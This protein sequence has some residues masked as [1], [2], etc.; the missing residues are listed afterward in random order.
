VVVTQ[1]DSHRITAAVDRRLA[2]VEGMIPPMPAWRGADE[3]DLHP[4]RIGVVA[5]PAVR[6]GANES[7]Q[8]VLVASVATIAVA[9]ALSVFGGFGVPRPTPGWADRFP[10]Q[11]VATFERP[12]TYAIDPASGIERDD[13]SPRLQQF[14]ISD[15]ANPG[16]FRRIVAVRIAD[17]VRIDPCRSAGGATIQVP[18]APQ[19]VDYLRSVR[20]LEVSPTV[21]A[22]VDGRSALQVDVTNGD[23]A[24]CTKVYVWP[25]ES[26]FTD[27]A[28]A[29]RIQAFEVDGATILVA[30]AVAKA[31]DLDAWLAT[32]DQFIATIHFVDLP[33]SQS[34]RP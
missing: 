26:A 8:W 2:T 11:T 28:A 32:A 20:G 18:S 29:R 21:E 30:T 16:M 3:H 13:V 15:P 14:R 17:V 19:F 27:T 24:S 31:A 34:S 5:G 25:N 12:F 7:P 1:A 6:G 10:I 9:L 23:D 22:I 33:L 4:N